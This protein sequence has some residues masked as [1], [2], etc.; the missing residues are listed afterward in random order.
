M[1]IELYSFLTLVLSGDK[2]LF[3]CPGCFTPAEIAVGDHRMGGWVIQTTTGYFEE[4][5]CIQSLGVET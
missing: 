2:W 1:E 3:S 4:D 5:K